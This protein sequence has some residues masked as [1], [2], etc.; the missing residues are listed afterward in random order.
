MLDIFNNLII[1]TSKKEIIGT[2]Y[3]I[4]QKYHNDLLDM[5]ITLKIDKSDSIYYLYRSKFVRIF[6]KIYRERN[7]IREHNKFIIFLFDLF[8]SIINIY[9]L[10]KNIHDKLVCF[11]QTQT[12]I[13]IEFK[14]KYFEFVESKL[15]DLEYCS[16]LLSIKNP[17]L[18]LESYY[19][20][21]EFINNFSGDIYSDSFDI[22]NIFK[23]TGYTYY[24]TII[25]TLFNYYDKNEL[26]IFLHNNFDLS[27]HQIDVLLNFYL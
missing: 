22:L 10:K 3:P 16:I 1:T 21:L 14:K 5:L 17:E 18:N 13:Q 9:V 27:E 24:F 26:R 19:Y 15:L 7:A 25:K 12:K 6:S 4:E 8:V 2:I 23:F 11:N 20:L